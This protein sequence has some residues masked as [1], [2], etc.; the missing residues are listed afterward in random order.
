VNTYAWM[1]LYEAAVLETNA[2][3]IPDRIEAAQNAIGQRVITR[4]IDE[5]ERRAIFATLNA[6]SVLKR[7]RRPRSVCHQC[8]D[9]HDLV[10]SRNGRTFIVKTAMGEIAVTLHTK[11]VADWANANSFQVLFPLRNARSAGQ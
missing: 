7:E 4:A 8:Q 2:A 9:A 3:I 6:L 5:A 10:T 1:K 11:C